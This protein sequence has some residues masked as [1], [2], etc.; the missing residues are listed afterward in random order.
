MTKD[1]LDY[2]K[3]YDEERYLFGVVGPRFREQGW[4]NAYDLM[5]IVRWKANRAITTIARSLVRTSGSDLQSAARALTRDIHRAES[6]KER[7][8]VV[9]GKWKFR[10]PMASAVLTVLLP[11]RFTVYDVRA[12]NILGGFTDIAQRT[13][14]ERR[15]E[16]YLEFKSAVERYAPGG[17]SLRDKDRY[18]WALSRH[19]SLCEFLTKAF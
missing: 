15:W 17:L 19:N 7:F 4:L 5:S 3:R 11:N 8:F 9:S 2:H 1:T 14:L 12:C 6:D 16:G 18:I 13:N 10:L